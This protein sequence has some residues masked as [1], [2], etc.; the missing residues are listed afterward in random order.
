V[1]LQQTTGI[2]LRGLEIEGE[3]AFLKFKLIF[4]IFVFQNSLSKN[5][6]SSSF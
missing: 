2:R 5:L 1:R 3:I 6:S 4:Y